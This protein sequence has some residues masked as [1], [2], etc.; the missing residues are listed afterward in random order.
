[1]T[2][3][4]L[5]LRAIRLTLTQNYADPTPDYDAA[6]TD[7]DA[8]FSR[9]M[10]RYA[11]EMLQAV[12]IQPGDD[13]VELACGTGHLSVDIARQ[14]DGRGT[15]RA[16]DKSPGMLGVARSK[17]ARFPD[18][19]VTLEEGDMLD[20]VRGLPT[21]SA[22]A[23][24]CGWA[25]CYTRPARLLDEVAR[26]LRPGGRIAL[27]ETRT[28]AL[29]EVVHALERVFASDPSMMRSLIRMSLPSSAEQVQRWCLKAGLVPTLGREG[30][31]VLPCSTP[32]AALEWMERSGAGAGFRD[33]MDMSREAEVRE[34]LSRELALL[35][36]RR[37]RL[38]LRHTFVIVVARAPA[39]EGATAIAGRSGRA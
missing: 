8:F 32:E 2:S 33:A 11:V 24:V 26:V 3:P 10:G 14:L 35:A 7:Y 9:V 22:D 30:E 5:A 23:V 21:A 12:E 36:E 39:V 34:R 6:S 25:I 28:D 4:R 17:L 20:F 13:V 16:V 19:D 27:I 1:M 37:G 15:F 38:E 18:L 29:A 31:Q